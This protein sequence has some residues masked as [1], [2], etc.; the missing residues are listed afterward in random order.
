MNTYYTR[1]G[2]PLGI[3]AALI[4]GGLI[5]YQSCR[6][7]EAGAAETQVHIA[8]GEANVHTAQAQTSDTLAAELRATNAA[9]KKQLD[10]VLAERRE[11]LR[12]LA[13]IKPSGDDPSLAGLPSIPPDDPRDALI[14]K[15]AEVIQAQ[16]DHIVGLNAM[17]SALTI[18]R[19]EWKLT[20]EARERQA[21]AQAV[22]TKAWRQSVTSAE[23]KGGAKGLVLGLMLGFAGGKR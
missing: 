12:K 1:W 19:D 8:D 13:A 9:Q 2:I 10:L 7:A 3:A 15:D 17:V 18:S 4:F 22:A 14:A 21:L 6:K 5:G 20:A 11:L 16:A 23:L